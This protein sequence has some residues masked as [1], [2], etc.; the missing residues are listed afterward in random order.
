MIAPAERYVVHVRFDRP[1]DVALVNR[2]QAIDHS[3]AAS[4]PRRTRWASCT[5]AAQR[6]RARPA[7]SRSRRCART[8]RRAREHR[9][10]IAPTSRGAPTRPS[11]SRCETQGPAVLH[12]AA[13]AARL[14]LLHPV[15]WSGTMPNELGSDGPTRSAGVRDPATG[16]RT[17]N[18]LEFRRG[19]VVRIRLV[20]ERRT[21]HAMQHPIHIHGQRFLVLAVNGVPNDESA[22]GRTPCCC[23]PARRLIC[24]S[25][26]SNP[27]RWMLHCHIAEHLSAT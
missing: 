14:H 18:R 4:S 10:R 16:R 26:S 1:G 20:N 27:G 17:W 25:S 11:C 6:Q 15:E 9:A 5:S 13:D 22:S 7:P 21:F 19:D 23:P 8:P 2:V 12:P 24:C 3:S